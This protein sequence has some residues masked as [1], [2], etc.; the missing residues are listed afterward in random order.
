MGEL[1]GSVVGTESLRLLE[2][3]MAYDSVHANS[4]FRQRVPEVLP[5]VLKPLQY[6]EFR[7]AESSNANASVCA[8]FACAEVLEMAL[9]FQH[10]KLVISEL[11]NEGSPDGT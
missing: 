6:C 10:A 11:A 5:E 9:C 1:D 7:I 2:V 4:P 8:I 3:E